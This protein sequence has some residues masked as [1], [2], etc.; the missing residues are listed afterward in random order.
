MVT[1]ALTQPLKFPRQ[2]EDTETTLFQNWYRDYDA[3]LGRYVQSDPIGLIGGIN[4]YAYVSGNPL[5]NIDPT[6]EIVP[7]IAAA[8]I[9]GGA[10]IGAGAFFFGDEIGEGL[11]NAANDLGNAANGVGEAL[12]GNPSTFGLGA[13]LMAKGGK[14]NVADSGIVA[15]MEELL[16]CG[17]CVDKCDCLNLLDDAAKKAG[18]KARRQVIKKTMKFF[19]CKQNSQKK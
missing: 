6:G 18:N 16:E 4:T 8:A 3:I 10:A 15:D 7:A 2:F 19:G 5:N 14:Q 11:G 1:G 9:I 12:I 13:F 17:T